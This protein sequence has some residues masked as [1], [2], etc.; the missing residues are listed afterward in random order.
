MMNI[1]LL[2]LLL[3]CG[4]TETPHG[5]D[6]DAEGT[7]AHGAEAPPDHHTSDSKAA[8]HH[9]HPGVV[10]PVGGAIE[11]PLGT[12]TARLEPSAE[13]L[14][15]VVTDAEGKPLPAEGEA[16]VMLTGTGEASQKLVLS[17]DGERWSGEAKAVGATGY[18]A[19]VSV[20]VG[21]HEETA[22]LTW[23]EVP[24]QAAAPEPHD[25][26]DGGHDHGPGGHVH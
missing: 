21:G 9:D 4:G 10:E 15:L 5:H 13:S 18:L 6:H 14:T 16:R 25:H 11:A 2:A 7:H 3:A 19:V 23:G 17:A 22:R 12:Y 24:E 26:G 20:S 8:H 1:F